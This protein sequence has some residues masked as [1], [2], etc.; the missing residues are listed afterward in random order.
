MATTR[1]RTL[2]DYAIGDDAGFQDTTGS[3]VTQ[4]AGP[5]AWERRVQARQF[6]L[7]RGADH[8]RAR[9]RHQRVQGGRRRDRGGRRRDRDEGRPPSIA[10]CAICG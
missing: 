6:L 7:Q 5:V 8:V 2:G 1:G 9:L 10:F 3:K 4:R